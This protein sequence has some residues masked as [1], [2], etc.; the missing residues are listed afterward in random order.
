M[1]PGARTM[2]DQPPPSCPKCGSAMVMRTAQRG[3][4]IGNRF[5]GCP[6]F[7]ER[8]GRVRIDAADST[9][10]QREA[11]PSADDDR[12]G[13]TTAVSEEAAESRVEVEPG[14][15]EL[16]TAEGFDSQT[17][18]FQRWRRVDWADGTFA[19][20]GWT[21]RM[22]SAG[23]SLRALPNGQPEHLSGCWIARETGR[24]SVS[25]LSARE[26]AAVGSM[27]RLLAR[28][29]SPP[30]HPDAER[31]LLDS[32]DGRPEPSEQDFFDSRQGKFEA[33]Q[34]HVRFGR[35]GPAC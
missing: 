25:G 11:S 8:W 24:R 23:G 17:L 32:C 34:G 6:T 15:V 9:G 22:A 10:T 14:I 19:R 35:R 26:A 30:M 13:G 3:K 12:A 2:E 1:E 21:V 28:G 29:A 7:P 20:D 5:W 4:N 31:L 16:V 33:F 18:D 27:L